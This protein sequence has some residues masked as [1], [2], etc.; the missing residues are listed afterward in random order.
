MSPLLWCTRLCP[1]L[2][3]TA[4]SSILSFAPQP[5]A[6]SISSTEA[7]KTFMRFQAVHT[8]FY[9]PI[10]LRDMSRCEDLCSVANHMSMYKT[11]LATLFIQIVDCLDGLSIYH[12][13]LQDA[14]FFCVPYLFVFGSQCHILASIR[15]CGT[16]EESVS[17]TS[18]DQK[19]EARYADG[20]PRQD[21]FEPEEP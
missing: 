1:P 8:R 14:A 19:I 11:M 13:L 20:C 4:I 9:P 12:V 5:F 17:T 21:R 3:P 18:L 7:H 2:E 10:P 16:R 15:S 6:A